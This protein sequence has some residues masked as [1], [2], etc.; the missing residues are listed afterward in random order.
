MDEP[1]LMATDF[2]LYG[3]GYG[4]SVCVRVFFYWDGGGVFGYLSA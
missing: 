4:V 2:F 3:V 1:V